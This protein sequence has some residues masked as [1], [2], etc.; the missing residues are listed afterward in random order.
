METELCLSLMQGQVKVEQLACDIYG[1]GQGGA[2]DVVWTLTGFHARAKFL[3]N[4]S[5]RSIL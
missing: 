3:R 1:I 2:T 5:L 4:S